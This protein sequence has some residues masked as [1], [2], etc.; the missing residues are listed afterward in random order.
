MNLDQGEIN[1]VAFPPPGI[2]RPDPNEQNG[3]TVR[4][5]LL[6]FQ[7]WA[8]YRR[9]LPQPAGRISA[10]NVKTAIHN[11]KGETLHA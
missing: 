4:S 6:V 5:V 8:I 9:R 10:R 1:W 7:L 3:L 2:I 11:K